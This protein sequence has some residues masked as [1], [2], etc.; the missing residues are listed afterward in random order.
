[1]PWKP[2]SLLAH[3]NRLQPVDT[4]AM[5]RQRRQGRDALQEEADRLRSSA[6][7]R[8]VR[9]IKLGRQPLCEP[10]L[11]RDLTTEA[12]QVD[13][14]VPVRVLLARGER[15]RVFS[16]ELLRSCCV[17]CHARERTRDLAAIADAQRN[18]T[19]GADTSE[20]QSK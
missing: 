8:A 19:S 2:K 9:E 7:W 6:R 16:L 4:S 12:T 18:P 20:N 10:C 5:Y 1:M 14:T 15:E 11:A 17:P 13:H 3:I